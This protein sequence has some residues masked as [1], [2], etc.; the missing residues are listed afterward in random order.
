M[1]QSR[2]DTQRYTHITTTLGPEKHR[3]VIPAKPTNTR[4]SGEHQWR[5]WIRSEDHG[6]YDHWCYDQH[7]SKTK[8]NETVRQGENTHNGF[9]KSKWYT[10]LTCCFSGSCA[11]MLI[12]KLNVRRGENTEK[13]RSI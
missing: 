5:A 10:R 7:T 11:E 8:Q 1:Q 3:D 2:D 9:C 6:V 12:N 4:A 13:L